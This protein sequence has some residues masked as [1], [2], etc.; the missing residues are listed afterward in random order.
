MLHISFYIDE[1]T[2]LSLQE[3]LGWAIDLHT[4]LMRLQEIYMLDEIYFY[5]AI[6]T[7]FKVIQETKLHALR[8]CIVPPLLMKP[9]SKSR[10]T[11]MM[12]D[13]AVSIHTFD[14]V[15]L[16][17]H[18]LNLERW[19]KA[20]NARGKKLWC[21]G[22]GT[23]PEWLNIENSKNIYLDLESISAVIQKKHFE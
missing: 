15:I 18:T 4:L 8:A 22:I 12:T 23:V 2:V 10:I 14:V 19:M 1:G 3:E 11:T 6:P 9:R 20:I 17:V 5:P 21:L 7:P 16:F 13:M